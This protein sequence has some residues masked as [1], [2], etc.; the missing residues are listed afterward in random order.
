MSTENKTEQ[1]TPRRRKKAREQGQIARSREL[2]SS[3]AALA[4]ILLLAWQMKT[5]VAGLRA[6][7]AQSLDLAVTTDVGLNT[8][9]LNSTAWAVVRWA[10]P[11]LLLAWGVAAVTSVGQVGLVFATASLTPNVERFNPAAR[12]KQLFSIS[13]LATL[14]KSLIPA[15][16]IV[17]FSVAILQRD[18][19]QLAG[20]SHLG[21]LRLVSFVGARIFE[22]AWKSGLAMLAWAVFDYLLER[23]KLERDLRMSRQEIRDEIKETEGNPLI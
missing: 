15:A 9:L 23:Q 11:A 14:L 8:P 19:V 3:L 16:L 5:S 13:S 7:M 1:A 6:F 18:A 2:A 21:T 22:I 10:A 4:M 12:L 20:A 17:Y